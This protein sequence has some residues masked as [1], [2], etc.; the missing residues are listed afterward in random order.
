MA[1]ID[2]GDLELK[3]LEP[4]DDPR[5]H[6]VCGDADLDDF[7]RVDSIAGCRELLSV[8]Y[9][10]IS[11]GNAIAFFS[12]SN[13]SIKKE[14]VPKSTQRRMFNRIPREKRYRSMPAAKIGRLGVSHEVQSQG[15]GT[16]ILDYLKASF[17]K[18]NKTGCRF[19][20]VD[21]YNTPRATSFY[22]KNG[23]AFMTNRDEGDQTRIMYFDLI[24]FRP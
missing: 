3:R 8:T 20:I 16:L 19:L 23:F 5:P 2:L 22:K 10:L 18:G 17:T 7:F 1:R 21:A 4:T 6:L 9:V 11:G 24:T 14:E 15:I 13:D 12:V